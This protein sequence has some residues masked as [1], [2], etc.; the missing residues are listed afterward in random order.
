M[1]AMV[2]ETIKKR[3]QD[4][5]TRAIYAALKKSFPN[6]PDDISRVVYRYNSVSVR[7]L[8]VDPAFE[9][10]SAAERHKRVTRVLKDLPT[11][12]TDDITM[13][14]MRSPAELADDTKGADLIYLE[15]E[16]PSRSDIW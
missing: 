13:L 14:V 16:D 11:D 3:R 9:G 5:K 10:L 7:V 8:I 2:V 6:L 15:F 4:A 12:V 1:I